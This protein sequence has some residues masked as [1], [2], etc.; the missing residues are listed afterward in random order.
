VTVK[1]GDDRQYV[2]TI[3]VTVPVA[4]IGVAGGGL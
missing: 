2:R 4:R 1:G 3:S